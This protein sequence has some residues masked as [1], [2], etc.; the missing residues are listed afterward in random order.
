MSET[1]KLAAILVADVV[2]YSRLAGADEDR[3]LARLRTLRSD[4][5]DPTIDVNHGRVVKRTGDG[6]LIEFRSVVDAVRCAIEVQTAMIDR[7]TGV[8]HEQRIEFRV[9][10]HVGDV[11]EESDGDLMGDGVNIAARLEGIAKPGTIYLSEDAYR[12]VKARLDFAVTDLGQLHLK[13]ISEPM[14]VYSLQIGTV[15]PAAVQTPPPATEIPLTAANLDKISIAVLAFN[16]MSGDAE[17]EYFS[18]G[19]SEDIITDLSKLSELHVIARNSSF[20]YKNAAASVPQMARELGVRYVLEGSVRKAGNRVRV[21][22]QLI[23][24]SSGGHVWASRYDRDLTDIFAVQ[25]ELTQEIVAALKLNLTRGVR[26]RLTRARAVNVQA[27]EF[28]LRGREQASAHTR[29]GNVAAR[30]L[31]SDAIAIDP[32]YVAAQALISFTHVLDYVNAWSTDPEDSLRFG[33]ELAQ[34]AVETAEEQPDGHF[35]LGMAC[36]WNRELERALTEAQRGLALSPNSAELLML[37]A[38]IQIFSGDPADALETLDASMRLD[39]HYP[40][41]LLQFL[42]DARFSLGEYERAI[43]AIKQRL[44][45]NSQSETAYALLASCYGH[46]GRLEE[47]R[48]AWEM[49]LQINPDFSIERRRRVLPFRNPQDFNHRVEG[50]LRAGLV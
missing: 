40:E 44:A 38:H 11:V 43:F 13:N 18:D 31:A 21:T 32:G 27:Y 45:R 48:Q 1:R 22:A 37:M 10:I 46:L 30:S 24:A 9:G 29:T 42:A 2:G 15:P 33:L 19:I 41:V 47:S 35:A 4:L 26:D 39:P 8:S 34:Q 12:Q 28:F 50:L 36:M 3:I 17:Q 23:D 16:N 49:A 14:R 20:V 7:N 5:I 6:I 25:D